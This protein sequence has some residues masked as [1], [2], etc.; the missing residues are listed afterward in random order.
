M[1][2]AAERRA[3]QRVSF[4][5]AARLTCPQGNAHEG[6]LHDLSLKGALLELQDEWQ[7]K[8]GYHCQLLIELSDEVRILMQVTVIH[9]REHRLGLRCDEIDIDSITNLRRLLALNSDDPELLERD[10]DHLLHIHS[11]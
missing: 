1:N 3:Y 10:L 11:A 4:H 7:G 9:V 6:R 5:N 8:P 2:T